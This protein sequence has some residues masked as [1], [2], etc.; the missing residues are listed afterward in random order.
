MIP[1][2]SFF[3]SCIGVFHGLGWGGRFCR[4]RAFMIDV[5]MFDLPTL[6]FLRLFK[7]L[8]PFL[9]N[10]TTF[11]TI[12]P[13]LALVFAETLFFSIVSRTGGTLG[14]YGTIHV[15]FWGRMRELW[16]CLFSIPD[17]LARA[18]G[19]KRRVVANAPA[20]C[21]GEQS[22]MAIVPSPSGTKASSPPPP[23]CVSTRA[24]PLC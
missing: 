5:V 21:E 16:D 14:R 15:N 8:P 24:I 18:L 3:N 10:S 2:S 20:E 22:S 1:T 17:I 23:Y 7:A 11:F 12:T 4:V 13:M 6:I 9:A 19:A